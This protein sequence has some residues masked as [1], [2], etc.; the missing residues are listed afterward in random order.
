MQAGLRRWGG[1]SRV[2]C[3]GVAGEAV[4]L[5][6]AAGCGWGG[7]ESDWPKKVWLGAR[8][9]IQVGSGGGGGGPG[10]CPIIPPLAPSNS[11]SPS[12]YPSI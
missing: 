5:D 11:R 10:T 6:A 8:I 12:P 2:A 1:R 9:R 3:A 7:D 4:A